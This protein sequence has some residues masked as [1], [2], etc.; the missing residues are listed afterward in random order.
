M[1]AVVVSGLECRF[2]A[3]RVLGG[4][5]LR[6]EPTEHIGITGANGSGKTTLLRVLAGL[7]RPT[8]GHVEILGGTTDDPKIR[9]RIGMIA[10]SSAL[11]A[12]MNVAENLRFW[13]RLYEDP[14]AT[15][16]GSKLLVDLGLDPDE[17]RRV[18]EYSQG[19][20][21]R[22]NVARALSTA[23]D[24]LLADEPLAGLD[25]DGARAV[26]AALAQCP[27]VVAATHDLAGVASARDYEL[28]GGDLARR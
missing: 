2:G 22:A 16:R 4:L 5:D 18:A 12:R 10:H 7:L 23:P 14:D 13:S 20:R 21:Q 26:T 15:E 19:M 24:L 9:R 8:S 1:S 11:Y 28:V 17:P 27:T 6:V 3:T 25:A